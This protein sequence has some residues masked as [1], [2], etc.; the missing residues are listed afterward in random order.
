MRAVSLA[1]P[2]NRYGDLGVEEPPTPGTSKAI[3]SSSGSSAWTKGM[4]S[5]RLAPMPLKISSGAILP[6]PERTA[7]R[8]VWPSRSMVRN[9]KGNDMRAGPMSQN[10][11]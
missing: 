6:L 1:R 7:V 4:T 5:S 8:M 10:T 9:T 3:T 11:G 2:E